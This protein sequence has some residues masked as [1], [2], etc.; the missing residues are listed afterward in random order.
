LNPHPITTVILYG[1][2]LHVMLSTGAPTLTLS[3]LTARR[4][5]VNPDDPVV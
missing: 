1:V 2:K 4:A 3:R 5:G